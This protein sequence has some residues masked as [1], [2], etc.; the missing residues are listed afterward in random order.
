MVVVSSTLAGTTSATAL[1]VTSAAWATGS[2][3]IALVA[4]AAGS[5]PSAAALSAP[6]SGAPADAD[7]VGSAL[8][9]PGRRILA[10][11]I[12]PAG[13]T[14]ETAHALRL[15]AVL[16]AADEDGLAA[17]EGLG[18]AGAPALEHAADRLA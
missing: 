13:L 10:G 14:D 8:R 15:Y 11:R 4:G 18:H 6:V 7:I 5:S 9:T 1:A 16:A 17:D 2:S 3:S 12:G